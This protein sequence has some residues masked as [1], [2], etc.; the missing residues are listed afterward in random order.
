MDN[1]VADSFDLVVALDTA[2]DRIGQNIQDGLDGLYVAGA[3]AE[4]Y[5]GLR[6]VVAL[7]F[8]KSIVETE[9]LGA[10]LGESFAADAVDELVF[11]RA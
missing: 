9:F 4:L 2:L 11:D 5:D 10:T 7:I 6:A 3:G 1:A 8:Q